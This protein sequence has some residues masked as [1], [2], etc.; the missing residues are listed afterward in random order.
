MKKILFASVLICFAG[1]AFFRKSTRTNAGATQT[2]T[3]QLESSQ[4]VLKSAGKETRIFTY[5]NDSGFY[6][7]QN[8]K[9]QVD[10]AKL[11]DLKTEQKLQ[12]KQKIVTKKTEPLNV[13]I[14]VVIL[15]VLTG[16]AFMYGA[17]RR[18]PGSVN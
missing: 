1:C 4:L 12:A 11:T 10:Q 2:S 16:G 18:W 8:I 14:Y 17:Y 3:N 6:Q 9:E 15:M 5:W 7:Y 13:W